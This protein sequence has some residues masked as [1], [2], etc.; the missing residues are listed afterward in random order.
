LE[1][2]QVLKSTYVPGDVSVSTVLGDRTFASSELAQIDFLGPL[3]CVVTTIHGDCWHAN[4]HPSCLQRLAQDPK[5]F[6]LWDQVRSVAFLAA[7][8]PAA[9]PAESWTVDLHVG[10]RATLV[11]NEALVRIQNDGGRIEVPLELVK[12]LRAQVTEW[13]VAGVV[14]MLPGGQAL[15]GYISSPPLRG[16]DLS[17]QALAIPWEALSTLTRTGQKIAKIKELE[18]E[19]KV[20]GLWTNG[21][22]LRGTLPVSIL[23][24]KGAGGNWVLPTTRIRQLVRNPNGSFSVETTVGEW[25]TGKLTSQQFWGMFN[26][27]KMAIPFS[28]CALL[29]WSNPPVEL[30]D[31][32]ISWRLTSGDLLVGQWQ[33]EAL[34]ATGA[35]VPVPQVR[36]AAGR[37]DRRVPVRI[38]DQWPV[39][40][41]SVRQESSGELLKISAAAVE[42]V[43]AVAPRQMPPAIRSFGFSAIRSDEVLLPGGAF[44]MGRTQGSGSDDEIP[45]VDLSVESFW[46][47]NTPVT[48]AQFSGFVAA[49]RHVT[50][51]ERSPATANWRTPGFIQQPDDPVVCVSWRDAV[52]YCNWRSAVAGLSP[53]Y[54]FKEGG[55]VVLFSP[56]RNGYRLPLEAEWEY[57][58]RSGGQ[59]FLYPWGHED[60]ESVVVGL[61]N[62]KP[63]APGL[64][65][66]PWTNPVKAFHPSPI[67]LHDMGGNVWEWCQD[68]YQEKAY[69]NLLRG[70]ALAALLNPGAEGG[71]LRSMRGGSYH[72]PLSLLRCVARGFGLEHMS[73]PRVGLRVVRKAEMPAP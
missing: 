11:L 22:V 72:N 66:W 50:D 42:T 36:K 48:V 33:D 21:T 24:I 20:T 46:M 44:R 23:S 60:Q 29:Q 38:N 4:A 55:R 17:G 13:G 27:Q 16:T 54:D 19:Q 5:L 1:S 51:A 57:A 37:V 59:D 14:E 53:C 12:N 41:F 34:M 70:T 64:D 15:Q 8:N 18:F 32:C 28:S 73:A 68:V 58:A 49:T 10:S 65:P 62:F 43:L 47:A 31:T 6:D 40:R 63:S 35:P 3:L 2:E 39:S 69:A 25:L 67:G 26:G 30:P 71:A 7:S 45:P 52:K 56:E 9:K 61:A